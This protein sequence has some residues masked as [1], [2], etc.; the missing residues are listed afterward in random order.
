[1]NALNFL[2]ENEKRIFTQMLKGLTMS[3]IA[4]TC[5]CTTDEVI[6]IRVH[7]ISKFEQSPPVKPPE[8]RR[9]QIHCR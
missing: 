5:G 4:D 1:M 8:T 7:I 3:E 2:N 9:F 6:K